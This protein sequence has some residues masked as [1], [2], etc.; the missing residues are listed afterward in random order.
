[1]DSN[2]KVNVEEYS[3]RDNYVKLGS[4]LPKYNLGWRNDFNI[5]NIGFGAMFAGRIGGVAISMT[6]AA[7]DHYGVSKE[8]AE[9][10]NA[11]GVNINGYK[12]PAQSYFEERGKGRV[13]QY[14]TYSATN[15]RLQEAYVSYHLPRKL[16]NDKVDITLS[17]VGRNLAMLYCK[18]PFDPEAVSSTGN[19][20]Q[21]L[22]YFMLPSFRSYG[23]SIKAN[24]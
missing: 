6:Q 19:Y 5:G 4:V 7:L 13:A 16:V 15:F 1:M 2:G 21:G 18:A 14:Y 12:V 11:G 8:S 9:A 17:V 3:N 23:F 20:A 24:F 22:D 10:R